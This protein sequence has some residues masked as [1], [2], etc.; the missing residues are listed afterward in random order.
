MY[1]LRE[2]LTIERKRKGL[3]LNKSLQL[4]LSLVLLYTFVTVGLPFLSQLAG[5]SEEHQ[6]I[7]EEKIEAGAWFYIFV[8]Q[9]R[10]IEP[11]VS[12]TLQYSPGMTKVD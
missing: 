1:A 12:N 6:V 11:R 5:F 9:I 7:I 2:Y 8:E 4:I 3:K 10:E